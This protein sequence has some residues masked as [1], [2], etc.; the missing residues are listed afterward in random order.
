MIKEAVC[1]IHPLAKKLFMVST[2]FA[3][4]VLLGTMFIGIGNG[5][6]WPFIVELYTNTDYLLQ[7][8]PAVFTAG[9]C[10]A[11][12]MDIVDKKEKNS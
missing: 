1:N 4:A 2:L 6:F 10:A 7:C 5:R 3:T 8:G 11:I 12:I 9:L